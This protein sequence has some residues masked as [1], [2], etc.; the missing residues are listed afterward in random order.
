MF[1]R[2]SFSIALVMIS[3]GGQLATPSDGGADSGVC[4]AQPL[5]SGCSCPTYDQEVQTAAGFCVCK[6]P[7]SCT[8]QVWECFDFT[9]GCPEAEP[10]F[11][12][13]CS[14]A[15]LT[16]TYVLSDAVAHELVCNGSAWQE[17][18]VETYCP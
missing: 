18:S 13:T 9:P 14:D 3:C 8:S 15:S 6:L 11:N 1:L 10:T 17:S 16:C 4:V 12:A 5:Q 7:S 2:R